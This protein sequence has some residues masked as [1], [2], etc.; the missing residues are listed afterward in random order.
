MFCEYTEFKIKKS[1]F[2]KMWT[3]LG[4]YYPVYFNKYMYIR[5]L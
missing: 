2:E 1:K 3:M 4:E 5:V